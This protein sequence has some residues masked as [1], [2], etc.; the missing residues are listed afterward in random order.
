MDLL[1]LYKAIT[2]FY[3]EFFP[4]FWSFSV[5]RTK[6]FNR[7][8]H[9]EVKQSS[10]KTAN[11][12]TFFGGVWGFHYLWYTFNAIRVIARNMNATP[13]TTAMSRTSM[14]GPTNLNQ[15]WCPPFPRFSSF[16][17]RTYWVVLTTV[18]TWH[19]AS[20]LV[21]LDTQRDVGLIHGKSIRSLRCTEYLENHNLSI[22]HN[23]L[24]HNSV[25]VLE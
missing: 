12:P 17:S 1:K 18:F 4:R 15:L 24:K 5:K 25:G 16:F 6:Y 19:N 3:R 7:S 21:T 20:R 14:T 9:W 11:S 23:R 10:A 2:N 8:L 22:G 13:G